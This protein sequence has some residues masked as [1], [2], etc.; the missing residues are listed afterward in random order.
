MKIEI[1]L[2]KANRLINH[3]P[4]VL[5]T[6]Q[7]GGRPNIMTA[8]WQTPVSKDPPLVAVSIAPGRYSHQLIEESR[9]FVVNVPSHVLLKEVH[10]CG[11][12]SGQEVDKFRKFGLTPED[13]AH[14]GAPLIKE[15]IAHLECRLYDS[16][17][18]GDHTLFVGQVLAASVEEDLFD[19]FLKVDDPRAKTLHHLGSNKYTCPDQ[20]IEVD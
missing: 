8:A 13:A 6:S 5:I 10:G 2:S 7:S 14:V 19:D 4:T 12:V 17:G 11:T 1:P 16:F 20:R 3:G 15:C 9:E 18:I